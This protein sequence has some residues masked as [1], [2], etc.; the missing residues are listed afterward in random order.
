MHVHLFV[1]DGQCSVIQKSKEWFLLDF[2]FHLAIR[3]IPFWTIPSIFILAQLSLVMRRQRKL[4][5]FYYCIYAI[6]FNA[7]V[8]FYF[9]FAGGPQEAV[10]MVIH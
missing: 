2:F 7:L 10:N 1:E 6:I 8:L 3:Y 4:K 9:I 5:F